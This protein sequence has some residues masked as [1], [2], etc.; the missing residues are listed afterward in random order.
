MVFWL[1]GITFAIVAVVVAVTQYGSR[2]SFLFLVGVTAGLE[3]AQVH[4][5]HLFVF[6]VFLLILSGRRKGSHGL[7]RSAVIIPVATA[8]LCVSVPIG[9][10]VNSRVFALQLLLLSL[11]AAA[12]VVT[13]TSP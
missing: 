3:H 11:T 4:K 8:I 9:T 6:A 13:L 5:I 12:L 7:T 2:K 1:L 10:L